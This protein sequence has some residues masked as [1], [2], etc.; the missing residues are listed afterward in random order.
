MPLFDFMCLKCNKTREYLARV[1]EIV[2]C[3]DCGERMEKQ[4]PTSNFQFVGSGFYHNDYK[5]K[6]MRED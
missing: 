2:L 1:D 6:K 5:M 4:T 3:L